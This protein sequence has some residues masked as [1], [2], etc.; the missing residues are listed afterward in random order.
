[1]IKKY[2]CII[3]DWDGTLMDS[4]ARIVDCIQAS[5]KHTGYKV[6]SYNQ[7]KEIIGLSIGKAVEYLHPNIDQ[8]GVNKM[9]IAY[10]QHFLH[11]S[12]VS[13]K[14]YQF[15]NDL[16]I[17]IQ[18]SGTKIAIATGKS[19]K[20]LNQVLS[21]VNFANYFDTTRTPVESESKPSPLMLKQILDEF[22]L[23]VQDALMVGDSIFDME[24]AQNINMDSVAI[25]HGVHEI[26]RLK[27]YNPVACVD[28]L[29][30]LSGW[31]ST[32]MTNHG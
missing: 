28:D 15:V 11:D 13:M 17:S 7:S 4:E 8:D 23:D 5:A 21:E 26:A 19:R 9:S 30:E 12:T 6:P 1:M 20:G 25:S 29:L 27:T 10:T 16:L 32:K 24:M 18:K 31:L 14:P 22:N 3:F 2:K